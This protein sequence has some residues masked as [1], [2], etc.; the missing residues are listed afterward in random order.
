MRSGGVGSC[1]SPFTMIPF[2]S[3]GSYKDRMTYIV[4]YVASDDGPRLDVFERC[5]K[6]TLNNSTGDRGMTCE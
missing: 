2:S 3:T 5:Q 1:P 4:D 6:F